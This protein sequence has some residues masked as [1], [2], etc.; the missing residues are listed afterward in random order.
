[1]TF[2]I[3]PA[4]LVFALALAAPD[5]ASSRGGADAFEVVA[6]ERSFAAAG[7]AEGIG[8]A[9]RRFAAD[10]AIMFTPRPGPAR[11]VI[12]DPRFGTGGGLSWW[13]VYAGIA[14]SG[15]LGFTTGPFRIDG[16]RKGAGGWFFTIWRRQPDG[17]WR[18][19]LDHG[20]GTAEVP[21][22]GPDSPIAML[23]AGRAAKGAGAAWDEVKAMEAKLAV[24]LAADARTAFPAF[25]AD[26]GRLM[27]EG[28]QPAIGRAAFAAAAKTGPAAIR[29][30]PLG[31][32]VSLAGDLA[33]TYGT[34][35]WEAG[36]AP[37]EGHYV[38]V[39]Q[40]RSGGWK[41]IVDELTALPPPPRPPA[42]PGQSPGG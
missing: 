5:A 17:R 9:F 22:P 7:A 11:A 40:R 21:A 23:R 25:L 20:V 29:A 35:R 31:G 14:V 12:A 37:V 3:A 34:A 15:D 8:P 13:P 2:R 1:M 10:D 19:L 33:Y 32:A 26:D 38:R 39:W 6:A 24:A 4:A 41:L 16:A 42:P 30:A 27:R 28:P 18:W 36:G